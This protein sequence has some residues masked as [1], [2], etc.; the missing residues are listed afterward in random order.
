[1]AAVRDGRRALDAGDLDE[2]ADDQGAAERIVQRRVAI[3][4]RVGR[5]R[6]EHISGREFLAR[7][8][9]VGARGAGGQR[10][11]ANG[12]ELAALAE[13]DGHGDHVR[14]IFVAQPRDRHRRV[15]ISAVAE[16]DPLHVFS[17][18][19]TTRAA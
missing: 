7:V 10:T 16:H 18:P 19:R 12:V 2:L 9:H 11:V 4:E 14:V 15:E 3:A 5:K 17:S 6:G 13:I 1:V 8:E